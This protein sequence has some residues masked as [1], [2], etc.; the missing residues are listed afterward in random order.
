MSYS[1]EWDAEIAGTLHVQF[2]SPWNWAELETMMEVPHNTLKRVEFVIH[3]IFSFQGAPVH[4]TG[5]LGTHYPQIL[6]LL[7][8]S[9]SGHAILV[10]ENLRVVMM[11]NVFLAVYP[12][13]RSRIHF[14][15]SKASA[16][17]KLKRLLDR[18]ITSG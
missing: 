5:Q 3:I 13:Y 15:S 11:V 18:T 17:R 14:A 1:W 7:D 4:P 16:H 12:A 10:V 2:T 8:H 9:G 6:D